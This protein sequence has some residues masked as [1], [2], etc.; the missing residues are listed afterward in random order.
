MIFNLVYNRT[1]LSTPSLEIIT[2]IL[3]YVANVV[4][5]KLPYKQ[6]YQQNCQ[7]NLHLLMKK[8]WKEGSG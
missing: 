4:I 2:P 7:Q 1:L 6:T 5:I 8:K 3:K